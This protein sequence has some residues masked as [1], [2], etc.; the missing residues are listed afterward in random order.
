M[1]NWTDGFGSRR[2]TG[3][4]EEKKKHVH[5][6]RDTPR[7]LL[8]MLF[9]S[10]NYANG[11]DDRF[12]DRSGGI[13]GLFV[14]EHGG[15]HKDGT[16]A[17]LELDPWKDMT[18]IVAL[19]KQYD[20]FFGGLVVPNAV[21]LCAVLLQRRAK[22]WSRPTRSCSSDFL[23]MQMVLK[24]SNCQPVWRYRLQFVLA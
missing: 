17:T 14:F 18:L 4:V 8:T 19:C 24:R 22:R 3:M 5:S 11:T 2:R 15:T 6:L 10:A 1:S 21:C 20:R 9:W 23:I 13:E 7:I 12:V 16:R